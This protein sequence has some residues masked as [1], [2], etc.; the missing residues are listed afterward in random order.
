MGIHDGLRQRGD[1]NLR[2]AIA[3]TGEVFHAN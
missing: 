3:N 2:S 1:V